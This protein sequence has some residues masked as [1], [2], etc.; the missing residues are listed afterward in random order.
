MT[1]SELCIRRPVM[2]T[3]ITASLIVFGL[4]G[5][6]LLPVSA[7]PKVD[8]PTIAVTATLPG[9]SADTMA[10]SVAGIIERQLSTIAGISSMS[11]N[12]SQGTSVITIQFDLGRN[13]DAA[14]LDVQTAL[15]IAQRRL[16]IEMTTP[17]SFRK[18]NPAEFPVLFVALSSAT[19]PLS[20]V[21]EYG[22][23]TIGQALSQIPGVAQVVIYGP[24][25][26][27]VRVQADPEAAAARGLSLE[28]I[29]AAVARANSSTPVGTMS[30]P[31]QDFVLQASG[32]MDKAADYRQI[33]VAWRNGSPVKLDEVARIYDSVENDRLATWLNDDRAIVL[34]IQK[35]PDANTVAVV[36]LVR[37]RLPSLRAQI[38]PSVEMTV[39]MDRSISVRQAVF[40]VQETLAIAVVLVVLVIFLFL[41]KASATFIPALAVPI[42][43]LGTFAVMYM[44][45]FSIN[46]MTLLALTL[47]V[48]FVVDDAIVMLENIMRHIEDGMRPFEAALKGAREIGFTII[49]ITLSLI[50]VFIPV[51]LMGGIVGRVFREFAV[52]ISIAILVSGF[53]SLTLT[54]M[55]C[56]R[57][58]KAHDPHK[59]EN[60][61]L[62]AFEAMFAAWLRSYEWALDKV[63]AHK[64]LMLL[65][66][67][68]TLGGTIYLYMVVPKGFFP[69]EDTGFLIGVTE[70]A[71]DTSFEAMK[72]RQLA[73]VQILREDPA[74]DYINSTVG[75]GG[76]NPTANYGRLFVGLKPI[77]ERDPA[78]KVISRLRQ[79]A[80]QVPGI[81]AFF[82]SIQNLNVGGRISKSQYQY[83]M[84]G[85]DTEA[86]YRL[87]PEMRDKIAKLRGLLDVTTDLYIR[88]PQMTV[89]I[90]RE[91][92]AVYG[93]TV[94]QVRNQLYNAYG[95]RQIG[96]IY[97]P[98][99]DY[100]IILEV[101]PQFRVD[102]NDLSKLYLKTANNQTIPIEAVARMVPSIGAL[103]INHQGQQ[104]AVTISFNLAEGRS[105][106]EAVDRITQIERESNL[107]ATI[108]TGFSGTA[109]VF[110]ES[111]RG[112]GVLILAAVFAA[113]VILGILY[114]SFIHP[115]TIISGL[116]SA[117]IGAIL[118][119]MLFKMELSVIAMIGI[120]MLVG[121]VKKNAIMMVDFALERRRVGLS[122]EHAIREA[123]LLR[124]R[125]I[126]M[127]TL[128][129]I[130]GT[131]PIALGAG[132]GAELRQPLG[133]AVV[134]G[135]LVS[136]LLTLFIT[137]VIYIYLDKID[138]KLKR[139]LEPQLEELPEDRPRA[140]AAE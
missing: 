50:A 11:S 119:L 109:Q 97:T 115:I 52:T 55:L 51:L 71:T 15:T 75:A 49:S 73:L 111:L 62:R 106:G 30:G 23:I 105:L 66:T 80:A 28:D 32:Q 85:S 78:P 46:N 139:R 54:P 69:Q 125:P 113:F 84:Q 121:I 70:A 126:M 4:F 21:N 5:Y 9:A 48:G 31:K 14:A 53:V 129:A 90:D 68:A 1:L 117:G 7:L 89:E 10:A 26:F 120:V 58:L 6:R 132:A 103:Q 101:Q 41:R 65:V 72:E 133:V 83:V 45:D 91:K 118:T 40:D 61:V 131:L 77:K 3:L 36:D 136:Q 57:M 104:P 8:F 123:A 110:Q 124:F 93:I 13:I 24:Q 88:N 108:F 98:T 135:L 33:V 19:L 92:A 134:G 82:Q 37:E 63:L 76:P 95:S 102:P 34:A 96:T 17:P 94:D 29:R 16:P 60:V 138:R 56:A 100:Q 116:P 127:T 38:P 39:T 140:V 67:F 2:T 87:A 130:F 44:L 18:V 27:A 114:E 112:Q 137:P 12:S 81:Q 20:A 42:S 35:Q 79:Q 122:A 128:A 22:D 64:F 25:K 86:L 43:L 74:V 107:P 59:R 47:S 99:N